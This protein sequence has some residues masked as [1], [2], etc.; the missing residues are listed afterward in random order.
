M[1]SFTERLKIILDWDGKAADTGLKGFVGKIKEAEGVTGKLK[2]G[3][4]GAKDSITAN[5]GAIATTA[6]ASLVAFGVKAVGAF[7]ETAK[8]AIDLGKATALSTEEASR[9]IAVADDYQVSVEDLETGLGQIAKRLDTAPW[10]KYGIAV[11]DASG[12]AR[13]VND[14]LIDTLSMLSGTGN[15][16][17][18]AR[19]AAELLG[20]GWANIAPIIG[21]TRTEYEDMLGS[22]EAGQV[23]TEEEAQKAENWR[24]AMDKLQDALGE[25]TLAVG[26]VVAGMAPMV[27]RMADLVAGAKELNDALGVID[28]ASGAL[29]LANPIS[30]TTTAL[31]SLNETADYSQ[32]PLAEFIPLMQRLGFSVED[33]R[34]VI[35]DW[36]AANEGKAIPSLEDLMTAIYGADGAAAAGADARQEYYESRQRAASADNDAADAARDAAR[37]TGALGDTLNDIA[38]AYMAAYKGQQ[39]YE[40][41]TLDLAEA[42]LDLADQQSK[43]EAILADSNATDEDKQRALIALRRAQMDV[44]Q[45]VEDASKAFA[46]SQGASSGS[47]AE[48]MLQIDALQRM[49]AQYPEL[50]KE[51]DAYIATLR[52]IP[53][54]V[55]TNVGVQY[56]SG[57]TGGNTGDVSQV[58]T[59]GGRGPA[60]IQSASG[61]RGGNTLN[62]NLTGG[63]ITS[64]QAGQE[65][66][67]AITRAVNDGTVLPWA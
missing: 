16:T 18:R 4:A 64:A 27:D 32:I 40:G 58:N 61:G 37:A 53:G 67:D 20:R 25:V 9:W 6:G 21:H 36:A 14:I 31:D 34:K 26:D 1:A 43:T 48:A 15:E 33:G 24:L 51:I 54:V 60:Q 59:G 47:R 41:A 17:E 23:I 42:Q 10:E 63:V 56:A 65:I 55:N 49:K 13:S 38:D 29:D 5:A 57:A 22:V 44:A 52:K 8:A 19:I 39:K 28:K 46:A 7:T 50:S 66:I 30:A 3:F 2:A 35:E 62:V 45:A 12:N 11:R